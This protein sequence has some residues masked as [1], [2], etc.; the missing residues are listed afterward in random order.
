M[1]TIL[2]FKMAVV[3]S[4]I[5]CCILLI[6]LHVILLNLLIFCPLHI[7][8][9]FTYLLFYSPTLY[10][11]LFYYDSV[12]TVKFE[13]GFYSYMSLLTK[14]S[15]SE[16]FFFS[17]YCA[18]EQHCWSI[19]FTVLFCLYP[20]ESSSFGDFALNI[21]QEKSVTNLLFIFFYLNNLNI[22]KF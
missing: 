20:L 12:D 17:S 7:F 14:P 19:W 15:T 21:V 13:M 11:T 18:L 1:S 16:V 22:F 2:I 6:Q 5:K 8:Q 4:V 3:C 10:F 9:L